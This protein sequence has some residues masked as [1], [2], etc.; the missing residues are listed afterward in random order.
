MGFVGIDQFNDPTMLPAGF[1]Q[2]AENVRV[3]AGSVVT[4]KG[5]H[6]LVS[7]SGI[8][9]G[10][11]FSDP[12]GG[13][14]VALV[15]SDKVV[16]LAS[17]G[18]T[19]VDVALPSGVTIL[20]SENPRVI[21]AFGKVIIFRGGQTPLEFNGDL[22][23]T[24]PAFVEKAN[25][26][27]ADDLVLGAIIPCPNAAF[28]TYFVNRLI[29]PNVADSPTTIICSDSLDSDTY[30]RSFGEFFL[31]K[32]TSDETRAIVPFQEDQ[33]LV[34][35]K[36][37]IHLVNNISILGDA[38]STYEITRQFGIIGSEAWAQS[39]PH[40]Y[41][42]ST[43]GEI[44]ILSPGVDPSKGVGIAVTKVSAENIPLSRPILKTMERLNI[45]AANEVRACSFQNRI[46]F[47]LPLDGS[48][49]NNVLVIYNAL[50][51]NWV[52]LD[53]FPTGFGITDL[54]T[55]TV[56]GI[57]RLV[58]VGSD[59]Y[60]YVAEEGGGDVLASGV[61]Y[62]IEPKI[63]T[64]AFIGGD[65][66]VKRWTRGQL[67]VEGGTSVSISAE[68]GA[69]DLSTSIRSESPTSGSQL[70]RFSIRRRGYS[71]AFEVT[72]TGNPT[73]KSVA[74]EATVSTRAT[75]DIK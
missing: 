2:L 51:Q 41:F 28:G 42:L 61:T 53:T 43:E 67:G 52:S 35:N 8:I 27:L 25:I 40:V 75:T 50:Y 72:G 12:A 29:V 18:A 66:G 46:Y 5:I 9:S 14:H 64:R 30:L 24:A 17:D 56:G 36:R 45:S 48:A 3:A 49:T 23:V 11:R 22:T 70:T 33:I 4:R 19:F 54:F 58:L 7:A 47:A 73:F 13:D 60:A 26:A 68:T 44:Q 39:G 31:N 1:L 71:I 6:V 10:G 37:S 62:E 20:A 15:K 16:F 32:G 38:S 21:Q 57:E 65:R 34:L 63:K 69:P 59:G 74:V 55:A